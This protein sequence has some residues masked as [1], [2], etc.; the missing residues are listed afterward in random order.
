M[1]FGARIYDSRLG[2]WL[3]TDPDK[4]GWVNPYSSFA[5]NPI[6]YKDP[7]GRW[8]TDG[9]YWTVYL[10]ATILEIPNAERIAHYAELPDTYINGNYAKERYTWADGVE[11]TRTHSLTGKYHSDERNATLN[12]LL[13][14]ST[15]DLQEYGRLLH[16][17]GDTYAHRKLNNPE[18]MYGNSNGYTTEHAITLDGSEPDMIYNRVSNG[19]YVNYAKDVLFSLSM[20]FDTKV[21]YSQAYDKAM[22]I[23]ADLMNYATE[24]KVS[25]NG[26]VNYAVAKLKGSNEFYVYNPI[27]ILGSDYSEYLENTRNYLNSKEIKFTEERVTKTEMIYDRESGQEE[28][29]P[30][31]LGTKFVIQ[32]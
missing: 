16:R 31:E 23:L 6:R 30:T 11:Q 14:S 17:L 32:Q 28:K 7:D 29:H 13:S 18:M 25:L 5:N 21:N 2:R 15:S 8:Q 27:S 24:N 1:D 22:P 4:R 3:S 19:D 12:Q 10:L 9:H 20:S 26:I